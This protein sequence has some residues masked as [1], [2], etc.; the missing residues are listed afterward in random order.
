MNVWKKRVMGTCQLNRFDRGVLEATKF[1]GDK[2][3]IP[4]IER[5]RA[6]RSSRLDHAVGDEIIFPQ[7]GNDV[8]QEARA[9]YNMK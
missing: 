6:R 5:L 8:E 9:D 7:T 4:A 2:R 3:T 1:P